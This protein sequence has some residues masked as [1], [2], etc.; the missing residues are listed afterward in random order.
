VAQTTLEDLAGSSIGKAFEVDGWP[1]EQTIRTIPCHPRLRS[2]VKIL[3][4][5][6]DAY[7]SNDC[8]CSGDLAF[9]AVVNLTSLLADDATKQNPAQADPPPPVLE[10]NKV[11]VRDFQDKMDKGD[12]DGALANFAEDA[13]NHGRKANKQIFRLILEDIRRTFPDAKSETLDI[14]AQGDNV[15]TRIKVSGTHKG[16]GKLP[17]NGGLLV[18]V[19]P[20]G[21]HYEIQHIHWF[22]LRGG[23]IIAHWANRDDVSMM[24]Q[25]GL[26]PTNPRPES[27]KAPGEK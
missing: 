22:K 20:T 9:M 3:L 2:R 1:I 7:W 15:V 19:P 27:L 5:N 16:T 25:L 12:I 13:E 10:R 26:L 11:L 4:E 18:G 17:V 24:Q 14:V 21:K 23:K 8:C 6:N